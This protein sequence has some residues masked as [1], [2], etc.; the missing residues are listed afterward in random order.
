MNDIRQQN[1]EL[2]VLVLTATA[3]DFELTR[4]T[5]SRAGIQS[6]ACAGLDDLQEKLKKGAGALLI[7]EEALVSGADEKLARYLQQ[8]P[9]WSDLP[10][11]ILAYAGADSVKIA[12]A[13]EKFG[14]VTVLERPIRIAALV[15]AVRSALRA[16]TRQYQILENAKALEGAKI[17]L[18]KK[19]LERTAKLKDTNQ[20]LKQ[21]MRET[22]AAEK[23]AHALLGELVTAQEKE[24]GRIARDLHDELGQHLTSLRLHLTQIERS[25]SDNP[26]A[27][28]ALSITEKEALTI[29]SRVSFLAWKIRPTTIAELGLTEA[30]RG[31]LQEWSRNYDIET[32][33]RANQ[34]PRKKLLPEIEVNIYR[35]AQECLTNIAKYADATR[36]DVLLNINEKEIQLIVEDNGKGF[37]PVSVP[38]GKSDGG[39]GI[40]GMH[41]RANLLNG[42]VEIES[43]IGS[44]TTVFVRIP[45]A[46]RSN[47]TV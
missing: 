31:Y 9:P 44:G 30:L 41:E 13:M 38:R 8:Q 43:S 42:T 18:E 46:L 25:L 28:A 4:D 21:K 1:V 26:K 16:R 7:V 11:L 47:R 12:A 24:R 5:L 29:D 10:V 35:I 23:R 34:P 20:I 40:Q 37:D 15:S 36:V 3:K 33:F 14:N 27:R 45:T 22:E 6:L 19:V 32:A 17:D 39:L 2:R